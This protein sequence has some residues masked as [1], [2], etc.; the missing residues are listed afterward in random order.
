MFI[1]PITFCDTGDQGQI[2]EEGYV[3]IVGRTRNMVIG[4]EFNI[5]PK[6]IELLI[7]EIARIAESAVIGILHPNF[8]EAVIAVAAAKLN[9]QPEESAIIQAL[10]KI[11]STS[12]YPKELYLSISCRAAA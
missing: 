3:S 2:V 9:C 5:Y 10:K 12:K 6:E 8:G 11:W 7:D 1:P 4:G